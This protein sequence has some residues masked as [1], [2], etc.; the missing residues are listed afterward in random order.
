MADDR[1]D[2]AVSPIQR[3]VT[4]SLANLGPER[5]AAVVQG[6]REE[7]RELAQNHAYHACAWALE[8][9]DT[10]VADNQRLRRAAEPLA[11]RIPV[12]REEPA[13]KRARAD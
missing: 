2:R 11:A 5:L 13:R 1:D 10:L 9:I 8:A 6:Y 7:L 12:P 4:P 3:L